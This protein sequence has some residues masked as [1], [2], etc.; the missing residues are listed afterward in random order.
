MIKRER[1]L[2]KLRQLKDT[3]LIKVATGIRRAGKSTLL[4]MFRQ[5]LIDGG[6]N[7]QATQYLNFEDP[8]FYRPNDW[9]GIYDEIVK[10]LLP[11]EKNYIFLDEVQNIKEFERLA[12]GLFVHPNIDLYITGSNAYTLSGELA[13]LLSGRYIEIRVLP[14]SF[15]EYF[16][17]FANDTHFDRNEKFDHFMRLGGFP[18][19]ANFLKNGLNQQIPDYLDTIYSTVVKK[20]I[21]IRYNFSPNPIFDN[22]LRFALDSVGNLVSPNNIRNTINSHRTKEP[23]VSLERVDNYL[24]AFTESFILDKVLRFD[25]KGKSLLKTLNKYYCIDTGLRNNLLGK[26]STDSGH[27]L[28]NVVYLELVRRG[29]KV[30]VGK[31]DEKEVDFITQTLDGYT[32]YYQVTETILS[33]ETRMRELAPFAKISDHNQK[34]IITRD[35]GEYSHNGVRQV[36]VVDWLLGKN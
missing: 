24:Q 16:E 27:L 11:S 9:Q 5:E 15:A 22:V 19:V 25:I 12:D 7:K 4:Q 32:E 26:E 13:T 18:E 35:T 21:M 8:A 2:A 34:F 33:E 14:L 23:P 30:W 10:K 36:N 1:Y 17:Y 20:D 6:T 28:E 29:N 31:V 3:N